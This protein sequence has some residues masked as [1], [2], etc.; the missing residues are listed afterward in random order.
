[1]ETVLRWKGDCV[2]VC[3]SNISHLPIQHR[4][5]QCWAVVILLWNKLLF[6]WFICSTFIRW[7]GLWGPVLATAWPLMFSAS[8]IATTTTSWSQT[9]VRTVITIFCFAAIQHHT[10]TPTHE[11]FLFVFLGNLFHIDFGH[12]LGNRKHF[13]GVS[14][15]RVPFVLT[16]DFLYVM[17][18]VRGGNSLYFQRF[19]VRVPD[20][21]CV[22]VIMFNRLLG[23]SCISRHQS[24]SKIK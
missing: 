2:C 7:S 22:V 14:R 15:E 21:V 16:P 4:P 11:H 5:C 10:I 8:G 13:L 19:R 1:M 6:V 18:R 23:F 12:I 24:K 9:K 3:V 17:G 20:V